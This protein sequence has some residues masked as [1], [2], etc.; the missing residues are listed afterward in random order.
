M[1]ED[2]RYAK[3]IYSQVI[4]P[5]GHIAGA[6]AYALGGKAVSVPSMR[7][8]V[9]AKALFCRASKTAYRRKGV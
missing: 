9:H 5:K 3:S 4:R 6:R 2:H 7:P 8:Q 1:Y